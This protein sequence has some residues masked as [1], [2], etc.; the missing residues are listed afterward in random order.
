VADGPPERTLLRSAQVITPL[1]PLVRN[2]AVLVEGGRIAAVGDEGL[3]DAAKGAQIVDLDGATLLPGL[4]DTH[5]HLLHYAVSAAA[6]VDL[7]DAHDHADIVERIRASRAR[8]GE[9]IVCT[10]VGE[11]HYYCRRSFTDLAEGVLPDRH[12][13]DRAGGGS[14]V[15]IQAWAPRT[16]NTCV[17]SSAGLGLV[18]IDRSTPDRLGDVWVEKSP[19]GEPTGRLNG[20][21]NNY[22][23][24][25]GLTD[26]IYAGIPRPSASEAVDAVRRAMGAYNAA[27]VTAVYE[28][29]MFGFSE[30]ELYRHLRRERAL[31]TRVQVAIEPAMVGQPGVAIPT[32]ERFEER[33]ARVA[34]LTERFDD[35]LRFDGLNISVS[36]PISLGYHR[37]NAPY[38]DPYGRS[39]TGQTLLPPEMRARALDLCVSVGLC[40]N[41]I[42]C[43]DVE[44]DEVLELVERAATRPR[45][46][47]FRTVL[48]HAYFV[49]Q[50]RARRYAELGV[51]V[52]TSL[53][54]SW[55][56]ADLLAE[57]LGA[58]VLA[59]LIP[60]RRWIDAGVQVACGSDWGPKDPWQQLSLALDP[61]ACGSGR[62]VGGPA[63]R[64]SAGEAL[65]MWTSQAADILRWGDIGRIRPGAHA[66]LVIVDRDP[67]TCEPEDLA[68]TRVLQTWVAGRPVYSA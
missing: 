45:S 34:A 35:W 30:F 43:T 47:G 51:D 49:D 59:D 38:L 31:T 1:H 42:A 28:G 54:F 67:L 10:P 53:S 58:G 37:T 23:S 4:I 64:V 5:P 13:L 66:D 55:G 9:W 32:P 8:R 44:H 63:Q 27:G 21:V 24:H 20:S 33:L 14:P 56:K 48:Q 25:Q 12:V 17:L 11:P 65:N 46:D 7:G 15:M 3:I 60:L 19:D 50:N 2:T 68:N 18:G 39:T 26:A 36:G 29:H 6:T 40:F 61:V 41:T 62:R 16:P 22:Y 52:T 57:R